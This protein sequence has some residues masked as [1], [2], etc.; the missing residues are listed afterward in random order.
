MH[1]G[2]AG[3]EREEST[4]N[5]RENVAADTVCGRVVPPER[6]TPERRVEEERARFK[7]ETGGTAAGG[8][9]PGQLRQNAPDRSGPVKVWFNRFSWAPGWL[10][11]GQNMGEKHVQPACDT[12]FSSINKKDGQQGQINRE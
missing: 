12:L 6:N 11:T 3:E 7:P 1:R 2:D 8:A 10:P 9:S 5:L 4:R